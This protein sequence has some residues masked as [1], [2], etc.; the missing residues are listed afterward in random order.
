MRRKVFVLFHRLLS[1]IKFPHSLA[2]GKYSFCNQTLYS[3]HFLSPSVLSC[4]HTKY[5]H[6]MCLCLCVYALFS[7]MS[8]INV[9]VTKTHIICGLTIFTTKITANSFSTQPLVSHHMY[10]FPIYCYYYVFL[11]LSHFLRFVS[12]L[13]FSVCVFVYVSLPSFVYLQCDYHTRMHV[14]CV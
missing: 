12:V 5:T 10:T 13:L 4:L 6:K 2:H 14:S 11:F 9:D 7:W 3:S 8:T 1:T